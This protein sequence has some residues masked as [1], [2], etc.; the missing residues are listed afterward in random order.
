MSGSEEY[1]TYECHVGDVAMLDGIDV[2]QLE[3]KPGRW[4]LFQ[5]KIFTLVSRGKIP[6]LCHIAGA[7]IDIGLVTISR[8]LRSYGTL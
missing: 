3:E 1:A 6:D 5:R 4:R 8:A 7:L 2:Q